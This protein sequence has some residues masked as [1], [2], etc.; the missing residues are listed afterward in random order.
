[1]NLCEFCIYYQ[2]TIGNAM[3]NLAGEDHFCGCNLEM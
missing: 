2:K 3:V 1:M